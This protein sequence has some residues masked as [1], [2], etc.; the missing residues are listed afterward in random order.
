MISIPLGKIA[1]PTPGTPVA[2]TLTDAQKALLPP[3]GLVAKIEA[4]ADPA[5]SGAVQ[6]KQGGVALASLPVP[7]NGHADTWATPEGASVN[8]LAFAVDAAQAGNGPF[9]T[10]WVE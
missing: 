7:A 5:D 8:P 6:I 9:V 10:L 2:L 4:H 1:V 3:S